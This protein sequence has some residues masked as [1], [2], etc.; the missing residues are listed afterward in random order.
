[1]SDYTRDALLIFVAVAFLIN[2]YLNIW[3]SSRKKLSNENGFLRDLNEQLSKRNY[4]LEEILELERKNFK[5]YKDM[6]EQKV[7]ILQGVVTT[8]GEK[9]GV[10]VSK[11]KV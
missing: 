3:P 2:I 1:M 5:E 6:M 9:I 10:D 11:I 7:L 4:D 8:L